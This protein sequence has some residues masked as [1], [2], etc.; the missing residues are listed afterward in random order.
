MVDDAGAE[1]WPIGQARLYTRECFEAIGGMPPC[2]GADMI[3]VTYANLRGFRTLT[4][5]D[6]S[7]RHLRPMGSADGARRG[8][9]R[10][11]R[12]QY[13]VHYGPL[14]VL[15]RSFVVA[16]RFR[17]YGTSGFWFLLGYVEA[18]VRRVPRVPDPEFR[19]FA[20]AEQ[21]RRMGAAGR[22]VLGLGRSSVTTH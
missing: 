14:W 2:L 8:R 4:F 15:L 7:V 21:R 22:R 1:M 19:A 10:E 12:Y 3:T 18:A 6:L 11:G 20:R 17:P 16:R 5:L 13:I 9:R